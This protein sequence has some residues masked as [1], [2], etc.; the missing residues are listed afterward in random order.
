VTSGQSRVTQADLRRKVPIVISEMERMMEAAAGGT[1]M[2]YTGIS[3]LPCVLN[4]LLRR[5]TIRSRSD[6]HAAAEVLRDTALSI[7]KLKVAPCAN[8]ASKD[9]MIDEQG[10]VLAWHVFDRGTTGEP[11]WERATLALTSPLTMVCRYESEPFW[12]NEAGVHTQQENPHL[13]GLDL[14]DFSERAMTEAAIVV[15]VHMPYG[16]IGAVSF[17]P[18]TPR[19]DLTRE[20]AEYGDLLGLLARKFVGSYT[21]VADKQRLIPPD[22]QMSKREIEILRW[23]AVGKTDSEIARIRGRSCAT[24]RFH[25]HSAQMKLNAV[26]RSQ[27]VFKAAQLGY[28]GSLT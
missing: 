27:A 11:W 10:K 16:Q 15:P 13:A 25:I 28:L 3:G 24:I 18:L 4:D 1:A 20:F 6:I 8:I 12:V 7:A 14:R 19:S 21:R 26:N 22:V 5:V 9:P 2:D 23:I 17:L